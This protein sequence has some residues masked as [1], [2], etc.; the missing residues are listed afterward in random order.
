[1]LLGNTL[2]GNIQSLSLTQKS[3]CFWVFI[4]ISIFIGA[5]SDVGHSD[6][7]WHNGSRINTSDFLQSN[8]SVCHEMTWPLTYD[9]GINLNPKQCETG[10]SY[11]ICQYKCKYFS[12]YVELNCLISLYSF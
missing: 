12:S 7:S 9:D 3:I 6:W 5:R 10:R 11:Y 8:S 1:M 4:D 2:P